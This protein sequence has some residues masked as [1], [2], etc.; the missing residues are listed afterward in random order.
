MRIPHTRKGPSNRHE[1]FYFGESTLGTDNGPLRLA[2]APGTIP[3][4]RFFV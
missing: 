3:R 4:G 1:L 2:A